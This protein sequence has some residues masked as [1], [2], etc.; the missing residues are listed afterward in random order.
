MLAGRVMSHWLGPP[1]ILMAVLVCA[2]VRSVPVAAEPAQCTPVARVVSIQGTVQIWRAGQSGWSYIRKLDTAL[3]QGDL[4]HTDPGSRAALLI[5]PETLVRLDQNSTVSIKQTPDE[6]VVEFTVDTGLPSPILAAPNPCGAGYFITRFP[7]RFRVITP[8]VQASVEGTEFLVAMSCVSTQVA[9]FEGRVLARELLATASEAVSLNNGET[10]STDGGESPAVKLLV[11]PTDAVQWALYYPPLS[12]PGP[13]VGPDQSCNK[14]GADEKSRCLTVRAEQRL[15]AGRVNEAQADIDASLALVRDNADADALSAVI[16]VVKNDKARALKFGHRATQLEPVNPRAWIALS[17]AQQASFKLDDA[18]ASAERAAELT[19]RSSTAQTRVAELLMSLGR[20][21][22]AERAARAAVEANPNESRAHTILGFVHLAR[23]NTKQAREDFLAAIERDSSDPMA[24]LGL[25]LAII[26]D[27]NLV[28]GREQI[29][30]A[31]ALDPTNALIRSYVGKAYYEENNKE[32]DKLASIQFGIA[33]Q[34]DPKDPT[35][36]FYDAIL[37][38]AQNR[39]VEALKDLQKSIGLNDRRAVYRSRLM[40]DQDSASR[41][42]GLARIYSDLGFDQLAIREA[43]VSLSADPGSYSAHQLLADSYL[44][45]PRHEIARA[46][47][48][49]QAQLRQPAALRH[50]GGWCL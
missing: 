34:L 9:V 11:K 42:A 46:S 20:I 29:E 19:P 38:Q 48:Q 18:L 41:S 24:R 33:K 15:R 8:F 1:A 6:T 30:I 22:T 31:V 12:E 37:K 50:V 36:W 32:R 4:L 14:A 49:L 2:C 16:N 17:Y 21:K 26:R 3:C 39:P 45:L 47:E 35:P 40:L 25:G 44:A 28:A 43:S 7:L 23:I 13:G 27:G 5:S 10:F